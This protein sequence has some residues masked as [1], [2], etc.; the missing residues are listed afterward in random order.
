LPKAAAEESA[1]YLFVLDMDRLFI[2]EKARIYEN[3]DPSEYVRVDQE[4]YRLAAFTPEFLVSLQSYFSIQL[5]APIRLAI[6]SGGALTRNLGVVRTLPLSLSLR[7][8][9][10]VEDVRSFDDLVLLRDLPEGISKS[11]ALPYVRSLGGQDQVPFFELFTKDL[12]IFQTPMDHVLIF[13]DNL[14]AIPLNQIQSLLLVARPDILEQNIRKESRE[15]R[16]YSVVEGHRDPVQIAR[17]RYRLARAVGVLDLAVERFMSGQAPTL[18][19]ALES[20]QWSAEG[21]LRTQAINSIAVYEKGMRILERTY[22]ERL[23]HD[24]PAILRADSYFD[25]LPVV[26][27]AR[28]CA[29]FLDFKQGVL[30]WDPTDPLAAS[31]SY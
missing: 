27:H 5:R 7:L 24:Q 25:F 11:E 3:T 6:F 13:E 20:I 22:H 2:K 14:N 26:P 15:S 19:F 18:P 21:Q 16:S 29:R 30:P 31:V 1:P 8:V 12:S 4:L 17:A 28:D 23:R 10:L 9:D